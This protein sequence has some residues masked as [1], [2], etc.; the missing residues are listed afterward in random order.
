MIKKVGQFTA[1]HADGKSETLVIYQEFTASD[2]LN[3]AEN[4]GPIPGVRSLRTVS[5]KTVNR[6][7]QGK[8]EIIGGMASV[9]LTSDDPDAI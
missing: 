1:K 8:Y 2:T 5:G 6:L 3:P 9:P 4:T 7:A